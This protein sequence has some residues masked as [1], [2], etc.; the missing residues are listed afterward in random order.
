MGTDTDAVRPPAAVGVRAALVVAAS[1]SAMAGLIHVAAARSHDGGLLLEWMFILCAAAQLLWAGVASFRPGRRVLVTGLVINGGAVLVWALT[2]TVGVPFVDSLA[3]VESAGTQDLVAALF[4]SASVLGATRLLLQP[5]ARVTIAPA[6]AGA[7]AVVALLGTMP[8]LR[9]DHTHAD[10][11]HTSLEAAGHAQHA[12][13]DATSDGADHSAHDD[14]SHANGAAASAEDHA[15]H[16]SEAAADEGHDTSHGDAATGDLAAHHETTDPT[17]TDDHPTTPGAPA[18]PHPT[19]PTD[20]VDPGHD[21]HPPTDP[22]DPAPTGPIIS[23]DDPR[24]TA[25]QRAIAVGLID[26]VK[27]AMTAFPN[28]AAVEAAG[29]VSIKDGGVDG[30][31]HYV[32]WSYLTDG[33]EMNP[34]KIESIVVKKSADGSKTIVSGMYILNIGKTMAN[35][36]TLAGE[37]TTWH[38][39]QNLCFSGTTL[40]GLAVNGVCAQGTLLPT[41]PMLH[42]WLIDHPCGP[43]AGIESHGTD[44]GHE[45]H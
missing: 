12:A 21:D 5:V 45:G 16:A 30:Y 11:D 40:V 2:R 29:Y 6:W 33:I 43:F 14:P 22:D 44:C 28:V 27:A 10:G 9:A 24:L 31:E 37:L 34:A 18:H 19:D 38:D 8:A 39:H 3:E 7:L 26:G 4:A 1:A 32:N 20:P 25:A 36:P 15:D 23:L 41:P 13:G 17:H 42:V 35:V